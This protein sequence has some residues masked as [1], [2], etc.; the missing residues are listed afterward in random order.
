MI[1][2]EFDSFDASVNENENSTFLRLAWVKIF[3]DLLFMLKYNKTIEQF[4]FFEQY[5]IDSILGSNLFGLSI[6]SLSII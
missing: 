3:K 5:R 2:A 1:L 4:V 6:L